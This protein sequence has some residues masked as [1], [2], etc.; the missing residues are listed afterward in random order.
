MIFWGENSE[1]GTGGRRKTQIHLLQSLVVVVMLPSIHNWKTI[2]SIICFTIINIIILST[3]QFS[4][5]GRQ[6]LLETI[7]KLV[8][9]TNSAACQ[10]TN[11][12]PVFD[13]D[14]QNNA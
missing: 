6:L 1:M 2:L 10:H 8:S 9:N 5:R 13:V 14:R 7:L 3:N 4:L 12:N 11:L